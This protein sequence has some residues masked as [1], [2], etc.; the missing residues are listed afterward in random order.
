MH[1]QRVERDRLRDDQ[2]LVAV[3]VRKRRRPKGRR[4]EQLG[5]GLGNAARG[6]AQ[7]VGA[8]VGAER[9]Q[10]VA[11]SVLQRLV[12]DPS[13]RGLAVIDES[14]PRLRRRD[15]HRAGQDRARL[16]GGS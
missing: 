2:V 1:A 15:G 7:A 4:R 14:E 12:V 16:S 13:R 5:V 6:L 8:D 10:H 11:D 3:L 9:A